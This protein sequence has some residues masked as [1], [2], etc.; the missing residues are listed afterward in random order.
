M[1]LGRTTEGSQNFEMETKKPWEKDGFLN[2]R[3][4]LNVEGLLAHELANPGAWPFTSV[5]TLH[6]QI[7]PTIHIFV[8]LFLS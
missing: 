6:I 5:A 7:G 3:I 8:Y 1:C 4:E 2:E